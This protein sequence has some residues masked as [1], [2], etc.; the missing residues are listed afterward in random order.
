MQDFK[1]TIPK[2]CHE[3][4]DKM[5]PNEK[6]KHCCVC[7]KTVV[8]FTVME[9]QEIK[10][11]FEAKQGE[12]VCGHFKTSQ[13]EKHIPKFHQWL[14]NIQ[15]KI[16][17]NFRVPVFGKLALGVVGFSMFLVGCASKTTGEPLP[18]K[19]SNSSVDSVKCES[20]KA[21][22]ITGDTVAPVPTL[23]KPIYIEP[24]KVTKV[25]TIIMGDTNIE[26]K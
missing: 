11:F 1:I 2:P 21:S 26:P 9:P 5:S 4:W 25:D 20:S 17:N 3:D 19:G 15:N 6:G 7:E 8:D 13:V 22:Q 16:E 18:P 24:K 14:M 23:G 12:K 10:S